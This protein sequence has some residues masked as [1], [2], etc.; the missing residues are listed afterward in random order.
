MHDGRAQPAVHMWQ[1]YEPDAYAKALNID[2]LKCVNCTLMS[3][4]ACT[5]ISTGQVQCHPVMHT[6]ATL[7]ADRSPILHQPQAFG[8]LHR[9]F[10]ATE[11]FTLQCDMRA[12]DCSMPIYVLRV[13]DESE[14]QS[15]QSGPLH[16]MC[17]RPLL[18]PENPVQVV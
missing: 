3:P 17:L 1:P 12:N 5:L 13:G 18:Q 8:G 11:H 7:G 4:T 2:F 6:K 16:L 9:A 14:L 15:K 10:F